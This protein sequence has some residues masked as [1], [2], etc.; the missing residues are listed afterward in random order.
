L[1]AADV[2][3]FE[4]WTPL[5]RGR[6]TW[7]KSGAIGADGEFNLV[8]HFLGDDLARRELIESQQPFVLYSLTLGEG[9]SYA[10]PF[11]GSG[12]LGQLVAAIEATLSTKL[13]VKAH[14]GHVAVS[15]WSAG[16][17]AALSILSQPD[18][19]RVDAVVLS[20][21]L[22][23]PRGG[24]EPQIAPFARYAKRAETGERFFMVTHSSIDPPGF[25]STTESVHYLLSTLG[26]RPQ[27]VRRDDR[28]GLELIEYFS[29]GDFH[30]R[31]YAGNDKADHCAQVTLL[32]DAYAAIGRRWSQGRA[33]D[34][35]APAPR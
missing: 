34:T 30:V 4:P 29:R 3:Q 16:F 26:E 35:R 2:S 7:P 11:A 15:A 14:A 8:M 17:M 20:D 21:G 32:R 23:G 31:G 12:F 10:G 27:A 18:A 19:E 1:P 13:G 33:T 22:H 28:F 24:L 5:T 25:A 6:F 9:E